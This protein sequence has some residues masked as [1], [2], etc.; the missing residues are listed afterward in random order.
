MLLFRLL[1][2]K[3]PWP[4]SSNSLPLMPSQI[5]QVKILRLSDW[6]NARHHDEMVLI[7]PRV[8][9]DVEEPLRNH[10]TRS[11]ETFLRRRQRQRDQERRLKFKI[12]KGRLPI[13]RLVWAWLTWKRV[14]FHFWYKIKSTHFLYRQT[15]YSHSGASW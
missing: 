6:L 1:L 8:G 5:S 11:H 12:K 13:R 3:W 4:K 10:V 15:L 2:R 7:G 9:V 14:K